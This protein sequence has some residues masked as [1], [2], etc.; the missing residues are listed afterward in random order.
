MSA[1]KKSYLQIRDTTRIKTP[2]HFGLGI[3]SISALGLLSE[4]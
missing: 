3:L 2:P 1:D 4:E